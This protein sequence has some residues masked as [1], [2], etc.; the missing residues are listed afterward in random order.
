VLVDRK[1]ATCNITWGDAVSEECHNLL[2]STIRKLREGAGMNSQKKL[3]VRAGISQGYLSQ[4]ENGE[5]RSVSPDTAEKLA[6]AL[7]VQV[8]ELTALM[9]GGAAAAIEG[10]HQIPLVGVVS[11]GEGADE[12]F[13]PHATISVSNMFPRGTVA[14]Q[15]SGT[16]MLDANVCDG[17]YILVRLQPQAAIG[18][19]VVVY[20]PDVGTVVKIKRKK[21]YAS[22]NDRQPWEPI[23]VSDGCREFGVLVGVIRKC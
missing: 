20:V 18:E 4:I 2:G 9:P 5:R 3:A 15:V 16:S 13:G 6:K 23:P 1:S 17:D 14:Y 11:A 10:R 22:A 21:H 19:V 8:T 12:Q 7:G